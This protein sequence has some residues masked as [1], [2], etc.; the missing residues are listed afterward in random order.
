M[1][2]NLAKRA[3][4]RYKKTYHGTPGPDP[5]PGTQRSIHRP[6]QVLLKTA[7]ICKKTSINQLSYDQP[8]AET[9]WTESTTIKLY[10]STIT[11]FPTTLHLWPYSTRHR[12]RFRGNDSHRI[13]SPHASPTSP[14]LESS[15][16]VDVTAA[17]TPEAKVL[18]SRTTIHDSR[19]IKTLLLAEVFPYLAS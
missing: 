8:S 18:R 17:T 14:T 9:S 19:L 13:L 10:D 4:S 15:K 3:T 12:K 6:Y 2:R 11:D 5:T 16:M 7:R 1:D